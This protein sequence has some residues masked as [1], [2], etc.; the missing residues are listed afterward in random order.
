[1]FLGA[2]LKATRRRDDC[3]V[4]S[5]FVCIQVSNLDDHQIKKRDKKW[6]PNPGIYVFGRR[7]KK[8]SKKT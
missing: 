2:N 3:A 1:M 5:V 8:A 4:K 7:Y 6:K